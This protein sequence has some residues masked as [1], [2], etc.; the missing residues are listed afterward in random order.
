MVGLALDRADE[1]LEFLG[2]AHGLAQATALS[3]RLAAGSVGGEL[4]EVVEDRHLPLGERRD[5]LPRVARYAGLVKGD[6]RGGTVVMQRDGE[7]AQRPQVVGH[8]AERS[9]SHRHRQ[10]ADEQV[11]Q[12][13]E[14]L[15]LADQASAAIDRVQ[16]PV[17]S[18]ERRIGDH[19]LDVVGR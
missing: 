15:A 8:L 16:A 3:A 1:L 10:A 18:R 17:A 19:V 13:N 5:T 11:A 2:M 9:G 12:V 6:R 7:I 14:M 4:A